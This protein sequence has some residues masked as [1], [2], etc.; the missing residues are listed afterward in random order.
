MNFIG[1]RGEGRGWCG[2]CFSLDDFGKRD[3][4]GEGWGR[5][6]DGFGRGY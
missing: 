5:W 3:M 4:K 1:F 6:S 2:D